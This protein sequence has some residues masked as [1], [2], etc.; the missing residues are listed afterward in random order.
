[1][2]CQKCGSKDNAHFIGQS[3]SYP[4][5]SD[6]EN[7]GYEWLCDACD[8]DEWIKVCEEENQTLDG[9]DQIIIIGY[10][11]LD[12]NEGQ[13][14]DFDETLQ[15]YQQRNFRTLSEDELAYAR[16]LFDQEFN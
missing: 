16:K 9:L 1:M 15:I 2:Q 12:C 5:A 7:T 6:S 14:T 8:Y 11:I 13:F 10:E 4:D 3:K